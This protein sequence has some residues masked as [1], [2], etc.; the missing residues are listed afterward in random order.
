MPRQP[1]DWDRHREPWIGRN[2]RGTY[3]LKDLAR[4]EGLSYDVLARKAREGRWRV[5]LDG[6][7]AELPRRLQMHWRGDV[8]A[9]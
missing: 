7:R 2:L 5:Q 4:D 8:E 9:R 6:A 1:I 3:T